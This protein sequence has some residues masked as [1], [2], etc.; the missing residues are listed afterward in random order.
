MV[1]AHCLARFRGM[2]LVH[3]ALLVPGLLLAQQ[4]GV[5]PPP[6]GSVAP[7]PPPRTAFDS[8]V[9]LITDLG[10]RVAEVRSAVDLLRR[11]AYNEPD[12]TVRER[13]GLTEAKCRALA[14]AAEEARLR[15]CRTCTSATVRPPLERYRAQLPRVAALGRRCALRMGQ[16]R[17]TRSPGAAAEAR[18]EGRAYA[19]TIAAGLRAYEDRVAEIR[20]AF[21]WAPPPTR[22]APTRRRG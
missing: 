8:T 19:R 6:P 16:L 15:M 3:L 13:V 12:G 1:A 4:P 20:Q 5:A 21:G 11:A 17:A 10:T 22:T 14:A 9:R 18:R 2:R 7:G